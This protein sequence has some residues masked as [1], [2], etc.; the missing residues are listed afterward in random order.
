MFADRRLATIADWLGMIPHR[1]GGHRMLYMLRLPQD[2]PAERMAERSGPAMAC[3]RRYA[4]TGDETDARFRGI[5]GELGKRFRW[6]ACEELTWASRCRQ[7]QCGQVQVFVS[8][9]HE[10]HPGC[11][12]QCLIE[13]ADRMARLSVREPAIVAKL[14][15]VE[16]GILWVA[17]QTRGLIRPQC[18][19]R[20]LGMTITAA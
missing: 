6:I 13:R 9:L 11:A 18:D 19:R 3:F 17:L 1:G 7:G 5:E 4:P 8:Y 20:E 16:P 2:R 12:G 14:D 15:G 10:G